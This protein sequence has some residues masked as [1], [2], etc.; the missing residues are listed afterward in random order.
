MSSGHP[1]DLAE[2]RRRLKEVND[3][4]GS[5]VRK[6]GDKSRLS[7][8]AELR[9]ARLEVITR[10]LRVERSSSFPG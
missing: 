4:Y 1:D 10:I 6:T 3:E 7:R 8:M 2:L 5:L 9:K